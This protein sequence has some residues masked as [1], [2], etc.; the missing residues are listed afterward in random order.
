[1]LRVHPIRLV[2]A[3]GV[4]LFATSGAAQ[5]ANTG[6]VDIKPMVIIIMDSSG[7]MSYLPGETKI[8]TCSQLAGKDPAITTY[9]KSRDIIAKEVLTGTFADYW[10]RQQ[11]RP[12]GRFDHGYPIGWVTPEY[13]TQSLDGVID[14]NID[15]IK[16]AYL[17]F[18]TVLGST[19]D[20]AGGWS[21]GPAAQSLAGVGLTN[22]GVKNDTALFGK[23]IIPDASDEGIDIRTNNE[24]VQTQ[25]LN[26]IPFGG[27]PISPAL[28]DTVKVLKQHA[29]IIKKT[30]NNTGDPYFKCRSKSILLITDGKPNMGENELGYTDS[31]TMAKDLF[32]M[33]HK[34]HVVG[35]ALASGDTSIVD[36][37]AVAG[38]TIEAKIAST[39]TQLSAALSSILGKATPGIRSRT[40][41]AVTNTTNST[42]D[43][44]YQLNAAY[45]VGLETDIDLTG[46]LEVTGYSCSDECRDADGGA[47]ACTLVDFRDELNSQL[48]RTMYF[49]LDGKLTSFDTTTT[50]LTADRLGIPTTGTLPDLTP[51]K[52]DSVFQLNG[53]E[54]GDAS[55]ATVRESYRLQLIKLLRADDGTRRENDKLGGIWHS[56]PVIQ[57]E[58]Q[59]LSIPIP[60][61]VEYQKLIIG[62]PTVAYFMTTEGFVH[63]VHL[64]QPNVGAVNDWLDELWAIAPQSVTKTMN[65]M[66]AK[67]KVVADGELVIKDVRLRKVNTTLTA[68]QE[69]KLWKSMLIAPYR[70]G[71]RGLFAIDVT[72]PFVPVVRWEIDNTRHC[73][74]NET[75]NT[76]EC[77]LPGDDDAETHD[78]SRLGY[79]HGQPKIGTVFLTNSST[80]KDEEIA[81]VF[82]GCGDS[83]AGEAESGK[84]FMVVRLD[85]GKKIKEFR[86]GNSSIVDK[87]Q[88]KD[89]VDDT[90]DF[91]VLGDSAV[92]NTFI[93]QFVTRVFVGDKGGQLWRMDTSSKDIDDWTMNFF[94]D[95]Y[96]DFSGEA[97]GSDKRT[98]LKSAPAMSPVPQ[99]GQLVLT[100]GAGDLDFQTDLSERT[101]V[102][103]IKEV[104]AGSTVTATVNWKKELRA[105]ENLTSAPIIFDNV[106]YFTSFEADAADAC[107]GGT[108]RVYGFDFIKSNTDG[109]PLGRI[110]E[111]GD[112]TTVDYVEAV[113]LD[114]SIPYGVSL[115]ARPSCVGE[116]GLGQAISGGKTTV[117]DG[118]SSSALQKSKPGKLELVVQTGQGGKTNA[119]A[120]PGSGSKTPRVSRTS[121][122]GGI[123]PRT[124]QIISVSWGQVQN[125]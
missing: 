84:C 2:V 96:Y 58:L 50:E 64:S 88:A 119:A 116:E 72:D 109:E 87:N 37:I 123:K 111:D 90:L 33:G 30:T 25:I 48:T 75:S 1:M 31:V 80:Q 117:A 3:L 49:T 46:Y 106:A 6:A 101:V 65:G 107:D 7:S 124:K 43:L 32:N 115:V 103:S 91:P 15:R 4:A 44:Q 79:I 122:S 42:S 68:V 40:R 45:S 121:I 41:S 56:S 86:N 8:P 112:T 125:L 34:V 120:T 9:F 77:K 38:G 76:Y 39:P 82:F 118:S 97:M 54:L 53:K 16:F 13:T 36:E 55:D 66:A 21:Y 20:Q 113:T 26:T 5:Q 29:S 85:N 62:R 35:F 99:R 95:P 108:G 92:Y 83:V 104:V 89:N 23:M 59:G 18:D 17:T 102:Y 71:G 105:R 61:F 12:A 63:A 47:G 74:L 14:T 73:F 98:P 114:D 94:F 100:F 81:A 24:S 10:C 51:I 78:F 11:D 19:D 93:G 22:L 28:S 69:A 70:Q 110:D 60:S 52:K 27:T 67:A 57:T